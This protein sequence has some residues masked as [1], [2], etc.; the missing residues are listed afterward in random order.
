QGGGWAGRSFLSCLYGSEPSGAVNV[1]VMD[2]LSC[3]YGS[4]LGKRL[5]VKDG[6][7][8]SCLYGSEQERILPECLN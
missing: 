4:E 7:F 6:S 5:N 1:M 2:F 3:L 8:L